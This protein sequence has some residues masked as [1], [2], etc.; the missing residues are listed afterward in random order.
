MPNFVRVAFEGQQSNQDIVNIAWYRPATDF[1]SGSL[2]FDALAAVAAAAEEQIF[3]PGDSGTGPPW[4]L[5][6]I[7]PNSYTLNRIVVT[8]YDDAYALVSSAPFVRN[9]NVAGGLSTETNGPTTCVILRAQL[10]PVLG[11]G[12]GLPN[13][14]YLAIAP[15]PDVAVDDGGQLTT[16]WLSRYTELGG[17]FGQNLETVVPAM[18][19]FPIRVRLT[20]VLGVVTLITWKDVSDFLPREG[21]SFRKSRQPEA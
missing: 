14:G 1:G 6:A 12:I 5:R 9:V 11:P 21:V 18:S 20:R 2:F 15:V 17:L 4:G 8:A 3:D 19:W 7:M 10:E 13:R 16:T